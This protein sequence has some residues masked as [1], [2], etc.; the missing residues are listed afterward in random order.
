MCIYIPVPMSCEFKLKVIIQNGIE[1]CDM[2]EY[3]DVNF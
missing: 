1:L 2:Q 3:L